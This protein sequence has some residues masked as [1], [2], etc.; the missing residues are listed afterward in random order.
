MME[1][2]ECSETSAYKIQSV[3]NYPE[4]S[5]K[6]WDVLYQKKHLNEPSAN[7]ELWWNYEK[8]SELKREREREREMGWAKIRVVI[9]HDKCSPATSAPRRLLDMAIYLW[10]RIVSRNSAVRMRIQNT[11][12]IFSWALQH[13][14]LYLYSEYGGSHV[15]FRWMLVVYA[16]SLPD[17]GKP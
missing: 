13:C 17:S 7:F 1:Q 3:G 14:L 10:D 6:Q 8:F 11:H 15:N 5:T 12:C 9:L 4:E 16:I 2:T